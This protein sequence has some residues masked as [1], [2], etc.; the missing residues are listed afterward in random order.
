MTAT[1]DRRSDLEEDGE[2]AWDERSILGK[3]RGLPW[4]GAVV[5]AF[6]LAAIAAAFDMQRQDSLGRVYQG[7][8]I[9]GCLAAVCLVRRRSLFGPM[10]Q[11][12]L[13]FAVTA[14]AAVVLLAPDAGGASGVRALI[15]TVAL[16]LTSNFPTMAITTA[17]TVGIGLFRM[18]RERDPGVEARPSPDRPA[19][20]ERPGKDRVA[21]ARGRRADP[22][23]L[24]LDGPDE[25]GGARR[26]GGLDEGPR[27]EAS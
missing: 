3:S 10:V 24:E 9:V 20:R 16:P 13:V 15:F 5:L 8:Y 25:F 4:W 23:A 7:A 14:V 6:G 11:P 17:I 27:G 18:W 12:P 26:R 2:P 22:D 1:R 19:G 21:S